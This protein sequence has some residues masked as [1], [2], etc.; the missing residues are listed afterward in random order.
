MECY[1]SILLW[2]IKINSLAYGLCANKN[3][4]FP[5]CKKKIESQLMG[6]IFK[7][8]K[9]SHGISKSRCLIFRKQYNFPVQ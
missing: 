9:E 8:I 7:V 5:M 4:Q 2:C 6:F 3:K 1:R